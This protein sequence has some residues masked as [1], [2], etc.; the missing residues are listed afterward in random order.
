MSNG[1]QA[2][3]IFI[4]TLPLSLIVSLTNVLGVPSCKV[5]FML[6]SWVTRDL[7]CLVT[8]FSFWVYFTRIDD[9]DDNWF[10]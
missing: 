2:L 3:I 5:V 8:F 4:G 6:V 7:N 10:G 9:K 1:N